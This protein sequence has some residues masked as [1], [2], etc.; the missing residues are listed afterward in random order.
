MQLA[1]AIWNRVTANSGATDLAK[2]CSKLVYWLLWW[3][4]PAFSPSFSDHY[5]FLISIPHSLRAIIYTKGCSGGM[6]SIILCKN[7]DSWCKTQKS[8]IHQFLYFN[9]CISSRIL[10]FPVG[11]QKNCNSGNILLYW[12]SRS[13]WKYKWLEIHDEKKNGLNVE[14]LPDNT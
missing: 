9:S 1:N 2:W 13:Q 12:Y 5:G 10:Y 4:L 11:K 8:N 14:C 6:K 3:G 7:E